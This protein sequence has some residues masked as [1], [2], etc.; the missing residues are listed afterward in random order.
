MVKT[1]VPKVMSSTIIT[2]PVFSVTF[3]CPTKRWLLD[4]L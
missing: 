4:D 3:E 1:L 2:N